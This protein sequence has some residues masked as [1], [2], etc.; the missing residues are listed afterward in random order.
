MIIE[1]YV[2]GELILSKQSIRFLSDNQAMTLGGAANNQGLFSGRVYDLVL[3]ERAFNKEEVKDLYNGERR[4]VT[5]IKKSAE[6]IMFT[7]SYATV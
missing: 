1:I 5:A 6:L 4:I 3:T 2:N 7:N